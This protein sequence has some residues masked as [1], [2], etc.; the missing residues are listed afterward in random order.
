MTEPRDIF[1]RNIRLYGQE[2]FDRLQR[3]FIAVVGLGGVGGYA[4]ETLVRAG[5][6]RI[7]II[8]C[9]IVKLT[10]INRQLTALSTNVD[11]PKVRAMEARLLSIN[12]AA[13]VDAHHAFFHRDTAA[14]LITGDLDFVIDA[15]DSLNPKGELIRWCTEHD[16]PIISAMG[17]AGRTD[18]FQVRIGPLD[19]TSLC[20]LARALRRHLRTRGISTAIPVV[21]STERPVGP[22]D[23]IGPA[24]EAAGTYIRGRHRSALPSL[25][26]VPAVF[27]IVAA[28]HALCQL[29]E[30]R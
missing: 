27:G 16:I 7:R 26:T 2:G 1:D 20:P 5:L 12:P 18:P 29:L 10:D 11:T 23:D 8:D 22:R 17:A 4:A 24:V 9:D 28:H 30:S 3:S 25:P 19:S 13:A 6:G 21:Y 15:I 14:D